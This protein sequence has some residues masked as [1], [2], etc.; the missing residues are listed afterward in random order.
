MGWNFVP[1]VTWKKHHRTMKETVV[2]AMTVGQLG[3]MGIL[4]LNRLSRFGRDW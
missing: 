1:L 4:D 3:V 2:R